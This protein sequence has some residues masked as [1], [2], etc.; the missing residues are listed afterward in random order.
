ML[1]DEGTA[2]VLV[3]QWHILLLKY[4]RDELSFGWR[5]HGARIL[6]GGHATPA[7]LKSPVA[8][9]LVFT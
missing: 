1:A 7:P 8:V 4:R 5:L 9:C 6:N 2:Y 3:M